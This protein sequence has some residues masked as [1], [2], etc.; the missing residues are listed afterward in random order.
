MRGTKYRKQPRRIIEVAG[1][2]L[3]TAP[4]YGDGGRI[5]AGQRHRLVAPPGRLIQ[6]VA[7]E[8]AAAP[9]NQ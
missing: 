3:A 8:E 1:E 7:T 4:R 9:G 2:R 5:A 6:D